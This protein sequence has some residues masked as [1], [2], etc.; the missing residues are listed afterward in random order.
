MILIAVFLVL[1]L[2]QLPSDKL[3]IACSKSTDTEIDNFLLTLNSEKKFVVEGA[4]LQSMQP[5]IQWVADLTTYILA[6]VP[7][8]LHGQHSAFPGATLL[9]NARVLGTLRELLII[10]RMWGFINAGCLPNFAT[11]TNLTECL[12]QLYKL[13][14]KVWLTVENGRDFDEA[15]ADECSALASQF[16]LPAPDEGLF[17]NTDYSSS[18]FAQSFPL[19]Y[20]FGETPSH[21]TSSH[22]APAFILPQGMLHTKCRKD[23]VRQIVLGLHTAEPLRSCVRCGCVSLLKNFGKLAAMKSWELRFER[24]CVCWGQW[25]I[26]QAKKKN[27]S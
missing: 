22:S 11:T 17:G 25:K 7:L 4:T 23:V 21:V 5:L 3:T 1:A 9:H 24:Y 26:V 6:C 19:K 27:A 18:L 14:T 16:I 20:T 2:L 13:L 15:L 10:V 12:P 8:L